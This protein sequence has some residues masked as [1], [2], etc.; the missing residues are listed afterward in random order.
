LDLVSVILS[1]EQRRQA[2][3]PPSSRAA[4][5]QKQEQQA[6]AAA[7]EGE[8]GSALGLNLEVLMTCN[9]VVRR[10]VLMV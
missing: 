8:E 2:E 3:G 9:S 1:W 10:E 7:V 4:A 5:Q 6:G